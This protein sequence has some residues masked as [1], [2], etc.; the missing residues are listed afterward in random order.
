MCCSVWIEAFLQMCLWRLCASSVPTLV[1]NICYSTQTASKC[2]V[3]MLSG[4]EE[5]FIYSICLRVRKQT[6]PWHSHHEKPQEMGALM[7]GLNGK[8]CFLITFL[9]NYGVFFNQIYLFFVQSSTLWWHTYSRVCVWTCFCQD[10]FF[11]QIV[12]S[13]QA[14]SASHPVHSYLYNNICWN[15]DCL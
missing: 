13:G 8:Y 11:F 9:N 3:Y 2:Y 15:Q 1:S 5:A 4:T 6:R 14:C 7:D 10:L 12:G